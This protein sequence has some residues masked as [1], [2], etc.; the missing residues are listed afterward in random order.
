M[1]AKRSRPPHLKVSGDP[2]LVEK[3]EDALS[4]VYDPEIPVDIY[5][6]GLVYEIEARR[7]DGR[8]KVRIL[9]TLTAIGCP[10]TGS[11]LG[12][13]DQAV[14]D[15]I[16]GLGDEDLEIDV[17]FD[18]PWSPDMVSELGRE[19]LK[20]IYGYDVVEEWKRR[21]QEMYQY[22]DQGGQQGAGGGAQQA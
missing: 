12:Y 17:T 16:P 1:S 4:Q 22:Q 8:P 14:R 20:E 3:V 7:V 5:N 13:V 15:A 18:P 6:L 10:V 2:D 11:I 21:A 19:L 9:M